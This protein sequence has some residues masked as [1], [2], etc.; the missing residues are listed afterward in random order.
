MLAKIIARGDNRTEALE[1]LSAALG[2]VALAGP[3]TNLDFLHELL[4]R[5]E[6]AS[7]RIDTGLVE[8]ECMPDE[9]RSPDTAAVMA[10]VAALL[11]ARR[12]QADS[13]RMRFSSEARSP[14]NSDDGF[15]LTPLR[16]VALDFLV[17]GEPVCALVKGS[18]SEMTIALPGFSGGDQHGAGDAPPE[19]VLADQRAYVLRGPRQTEVRLAAEGGGEETGGDENGVVRA[20]MH[21]RIVKVNVGPGDEVTAGEALAVL[22]AMK[23]EHRLT[24]PRDGLVTEI[25]VRE[26]QQVDQGALV[27]IV[28][29]RE[30]DVV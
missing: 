8:R 1:K 17:D 3:R 24:A 18:G 16:S 23:M 4:R 10:G 20:P 9:N 28:D 13:R 2:A 21:G 19:I 27:M 6:V 14:W 25:T 30:G 5:D 7:G 29:E 12:A 15:A 11:S 22:E 26:G